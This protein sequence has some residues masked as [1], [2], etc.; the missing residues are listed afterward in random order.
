[1]WP[2]VDLSRWPAWLFLPYVALYLGSVAVML[3]GVL[4]LALRTFRAIMDDGSQDPVLFYG[5]LHQRRTRQLAW[6]DRDVR[7][8]VF[9]WLGM[10]LLGSVP[11][12]LEGW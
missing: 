5:Y 7:I 8:A 1:M 10:F 4:R 6:A 3:W 2:D 11:S 12:L 9:G